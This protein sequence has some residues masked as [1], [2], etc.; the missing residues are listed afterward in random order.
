MIGFFGS[1]FMQLQPNTLEY[2]VFTKSNA[3]FENQVSFM[4]LYNRYANLAVTRY[5]WIGLPDSVSERFLNMALFFTG[6]AAFFEDE[7]MGFMALPCTIAG[8][9]NA[10]Y[11]PVRVQA[12]SF[13]YSKMLNY[14]DFVYIRNN[15]T[16]TPTAMFVIEYTRRMADIL[17]TIDVLTKKMKHPYMIECEEKEQLTIENML[18][19]IQDNEIMVLGTKKYDL[20]TKTMEVKQMS[21]Q[22]DL[23]ELWHCYD[24]MQNI[25]CSGLGIETVGFEKSERLVMDEAN[26]NNMFTAMSIEVN[27][28]ELEIACEK[29]NK[30]YGLNVSV[31]IRDIYDYRRME[32][33]DDG[34]V[35]DRTEQSD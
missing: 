25:L 35:Y 18:K 4:E 19:K 21:V 33:V 2:K 24:S 17:R 22:T 13:N 14:N 12:Y 9:F 8:E 10:Y 34:E 1:E 3:Q 23:R 6:S 20:G 5:N 15:P 16:C 11:E 32:E 7:N 26:A 29:I 31:E 28:K 27:K 30:K